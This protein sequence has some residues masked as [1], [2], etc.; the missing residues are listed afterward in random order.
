MHYARCEIQVQML[1]SNAPRLRLRLLTKFMLVMNHRLAAAG[2]CGASRVGRPSPATP[3]GK[4]E[5]AARG[6]DQS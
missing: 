2:G 4:D 5:S 6:I 1:L 3:V